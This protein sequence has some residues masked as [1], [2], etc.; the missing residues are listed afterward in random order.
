MHL[1][2]VV[3]MLL[4]LKRTAKNARTD[5]SSKHY[6]MP[7]NTQKMHYST[8]FLVNR[9]GM[10]TVTVISIKPKSYV[11]VAAMCMSFLNALAQK[12]CVSGAFPDY[13]LRQNH[14]SSE[15]RTSYVKQKFLHLY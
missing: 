5:Y 10:I 9:N 7:R 8:N 3:A 15:K 4:R 13:C 2:L 11:T 12:C 14:F 1:N 6:I